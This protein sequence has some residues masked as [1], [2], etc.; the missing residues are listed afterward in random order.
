MLISG[1]VR[2]QKGFTLVEIVVV[3]G[4]IGMSMGVGLIMFVR[5]SAGASRKAAAEIVTEDLRRA[6][7]KAAT[8][9]KNGS[10]TN[11]KRDQYIVVF[12]GATGDPPNALMIVKGKFDGISAYKREPVP[13]EE[14][15]ANRIVAGTYWIKPS[16]SSDI[17]I[18]PPPGGELI[19]QSKG[20]VMTVQPAGVH[21]VGIKAKSSGLTS[22][23][24]ISDYGD[25][26]SD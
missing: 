6:Y 25:I 20:S 2:A 7:S 4:I 13:P 1:K 18:V 14:R 26:S 19:F 17:Q 21:S 11:K 8:A 24:Y 9:E 23:I 16:T 5:G 12:H 22:N 15:E 3:V 10:D